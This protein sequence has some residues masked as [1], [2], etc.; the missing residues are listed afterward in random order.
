[1][2][3]RASATL[4]NRSEQR[5]RTA[6]SAVLFFMSALAFG[7]VLATGGCNAD[8]RVGKSGAAD[9]LVLV[10]ESGRHPVS[11]EVADTEE[12]KRV[13]LM[14]RTEMKDGHGMLFPYDRSQE[15]TMWMRNTYIPLDMIFIGE[16]GVV[17]R[18]VRNTE[19]MSEAIISS[20]LPALGVLE[21]KAGSADHYKIKAGKSRVE[22]PH[23][24]G[25]SAR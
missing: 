15:I 5:E 14:F 4:R 10:T 12:K 17:V 25:S 24:A 21:M 18:V 6:P 16:D 3:E 11:L 1:M 13:G 8:E 2:R 19:P 9:G 20:D 22:H 23:F 7:A